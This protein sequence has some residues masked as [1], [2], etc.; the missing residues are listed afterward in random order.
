MVTNK[1][2]PRKR[3]IKE[4]MLEHKDIA[5]WYDN[6]A[7]G[8][9][10]TADVYI[11]RLSAVCDRLGKTPHEVIGM[12]N[13]AIYDLLIGFVKAEKKRGKTGSYIASSIKAIRSW[14]AHNGIKIDQK[15][16]IKGASRAPTLKNERVPTQKELHKIFLAGSPRD[17]ACCVLMAHSGF[18]PQVIGNY[19]GDDGLTLGDFPEMR[20]E[21]KEVEKDVEVEKEV[22]GKKKVEVV[23]EVVKVKE[24]I[25]DVTPTKV[26]VREEL[27]KTGKRYITFLST[28]GCGYLKDYLESR[29]RKGE[30]FTDNTD[31]ITPKV[32]DKQFI[33]AINIGDIVR[34]SIRSAGFQWRPYVLRGYFDT[35][36]LLA[37][38]KGK[39]THAYRQ[40]FMGHSGDIESR[41]TTD[42]QLNE[43]MI[44]DMREAYKNCE[45]FLQTIVI[46]DDKED[47]DTT[48]KLRLLRMGGKSEEEIE[49]M[50]LDEV[51]DEYL[52]DVLHQK[53]VGTLTGNGGSQKVVPVDDVEKY[54]SEGWEY[55]SVLP[56]DKAIVRFPL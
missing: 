5:T 10:T 53:V 4:R 38:S 19:L 31:I 26:V 32:A 34:K 35:Q 6:I 36:L 45:S 22:E 56:G 25:F 33:R 23:K 42:K 7:E 14:L 1:G 43:V 39:M 8:S 24:I 30:K 55:V 50:D 3:T 46:E 9:M 51:T 52:M 28:Q 37:E 18:R 13:K 21:E 44:D 16:N 49:N 11:R 54:I 40:F 29:L 20:V 12:E 48:F 15:I 17:R 41:Y 27:S 2:N 47:A